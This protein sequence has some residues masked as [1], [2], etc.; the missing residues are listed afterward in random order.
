MIEIGSLVAYR[1]TDEMGI[2]YDVYHTPGAFA[3]PIY[4]I[5]W[6]DGTSGNLS[7]TF[8]RFIA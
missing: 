5:R 2:V 8:L 7:S 6:F 3:T 1:R 4:K